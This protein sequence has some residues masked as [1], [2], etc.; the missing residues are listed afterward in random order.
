MLHL[1]V[2]PLLKYTS[3]DNSP[4][5]LQIHLIELSLGRRY[6]MIFCVK[7]HNKTLIFLFPRT[8][9]RYTHKHSEN[10]KMQLIYS[11]YC[12]FS[13]LREALMDP[14]LTIVR[15]IAKFSFV[16]CLLYHVHNNVYN[17]SYPQDK[18]FCHLQS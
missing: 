6:K 5:S 15:S 9:V 2:L 7:A 17:N 10:L 14:N 1:K 11:Y 16:R 18:E 12:S 3:S 4:A 8:Y 13:F